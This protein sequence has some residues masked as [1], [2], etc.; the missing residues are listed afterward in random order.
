[1]RPSAAAAG[2]AVLAVEGSFAVT[3]S[4]QHYYELDDPAAALAALEHDM[5]ALMMSVEKV[6]PGHTIVPAAVDICRLSFGSLLTWR[7][8]GPSS[9][10]L[11][12]IK[13]NA[14]QAWLLSAVLSATCLL[15]PQ[16]ADVAPHLLRCS[17]N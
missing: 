6:G 13:P 17:C 1:V 12:F 15:S 4:G 10:L 11:R 3:S 9:P 5:A 14:L 8:A 2:D 16:A 7:L